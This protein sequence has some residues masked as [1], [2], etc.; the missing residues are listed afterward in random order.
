MKD[1]TVPMLLP[2]L[3]RYIL[4][5]TAQLFIAILSILLAIILSF[6]LSGLLSS[7][8]AGKMHLS[9]V[10]Q[11]IGL[12]AVNM[13]ITIMPM[14]LILAAVMTLDR[15]YR[16][17]EAAALFAAGIGR[18]HFRR[19]ILLFSIPAGSV[20]LLLT[21]YVLPDVYAQTSALR[22]QAKQQAGFALLT[23]N[24]FRRLDDGTVIH[25]GNAD[26][27]KYQNFFI[28]QNGKGR[29]SAIFADT[30]GIR[31]EGR[32]QYL[33]L[34]SG[35]RVAWTAPDAPQ[36]ASYTQFRAAEIHLP[37]ADN[38]ASL[39]DRELP[40][41][42]LTSSP[43]HL[44]ELQSRLNPPLAMILFSLC[45]PLLA[46]RGP[47]KSRQYTILPAFILFALYINSLEIAVK[48]VAK[49]KLPPWPG[50]FFIHAA[51]LIIIALWWAYSRKKI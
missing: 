47:R 10:W 6:R 40:L 45:L 38:S 42:S 30:G 48:A 51:A 33:D 50:S 35:S 22:T 2:T 14:A 19:I 12:Q 37:A 44:A 18:S 23:P 49:N 16:E 32:E 31:Q 39:R 9:A 13:L 46:H 11:I 24:S 3:Y 41:S 28:A 25:T 34:S 17:Q 26:G 1:K 36:N 4:R 5:E 29:H 8:V 20:L 15:L 21:L 27:G 7:A 43:A